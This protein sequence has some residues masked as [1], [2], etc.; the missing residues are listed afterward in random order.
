MTT[1]SATQQTLKEGGMDFGK[2]NLY[3]IASINTH[4]L[5]QKKWLHILNVKYLQNLNT[6]FEMRF[7][8]VSVSIACSSYSGQ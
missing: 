4:H 5:T 7:L 1:M 6:T 3:N 2:Q 8:E